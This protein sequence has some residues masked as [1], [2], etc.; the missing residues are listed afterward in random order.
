MFDLLAS[1]PCH[2]ING[3][4]SKSSWASDATMIA[5]IQ[6]PNHGGVWATEAPQGPFSDPWA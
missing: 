4:S 1:S 3:P 5:K 6:G 2:L